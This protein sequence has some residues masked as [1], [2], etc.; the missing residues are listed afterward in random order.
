MIKRY[1]VPLIIAILI[2]AVILVTIL[3]LIS[4]STNITKPVAGV[5]E[6]LV[7][8]LSINL[9]TKSTNDVREQNGY[10]SLVLN[11][12]LTTAAQA[13]ADD[14][15]KK[16]YFSHYGPDGTSPWKF[17]KDSGYTYE[18]AGENL[19]VTNQDEASIID[20][21]LDS[22]AHR[23]NL[24]NNGYQD[25]GIGIAY[26]GNH[27]EYKNTTV[28][29]AF[30][31]R[32]SSGR[33]GDNNPLVGKRILSSSLSLPAAIVEKTNLVREQN[34]LNSLAL[35]PKLTTVAQARAADMATNRYVAQRGVDDSE[36]RTFVNEHDYDYDEVW[37]NVMITNKDE[38][39][40]TTG[41]LGGDE[42][43]KYFLDNNY[44]DIGIGVAYFG[45]YRAYTNTTVI[46]GIYGAPAP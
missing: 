11:H 28:I 4:K 45:D 42:N 5:H 26:Y 24:L 10:N 3:L 32:S 23:E 15:A 27:K 6:L 13:K 20:G 36:F 37:E 1:M 44:H 35:D 19:A 21:W 2:V 18:I 30:Y 46:V 22:P 8:S 39:S 33:T 17:F 12:I 7:R 34:G 9:I 14:M 25:I 31:G 41:W 43:I 38:A 29:V 16:Q 40:V